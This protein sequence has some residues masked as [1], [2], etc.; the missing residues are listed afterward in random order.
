M[1]SLCW[2]VLIRSCGKA[3]RRCSW[4][5]QALK[6]SCQSESSNAFVHS[7]LVNEAI[8]ILYCGL[9]FIDLVAVCCSLRC[10]PC[11]DFVISVIPKRSVLQTCHKLLLYL[12]SLLITV[13]TVL[14]HDPWSQ[15]FQCCFG[16]ALNA[17]LMLDVAVQTHDT[18]EWVVFLWP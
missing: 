10:I 3:A 18:C 1:S 9:S 5:Q 15:S 13:S 7:L 14:I 11:H 2:Q 8:T 4:P 16:N 12:C 17:R 6:N